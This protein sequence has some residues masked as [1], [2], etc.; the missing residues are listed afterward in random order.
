[1]AGPILASQVS[2]YGL[3]LFFFEARLVLNFGSVSASTPF[4]VSLSILALS[5]FPR[6]SPCRS[7]IA[8]G[9]FGVYTRSP[10]LPL[11]APEI[12]QMVLPVP[13]GVLA[14]LRSVGCIYILRH[15]SVSSNHLRPPF[16]YPDVVAIFSFIVVGS[17]P[18][19]GYSGWANVMSDMAHTYEYVAIDEI[20]RYMVAQD[21]HN[22]W[23]DASDRR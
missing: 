14:S 1:M 21:S 2:R 12:K 16:R 9:I 10:A 13:R 17:A 11:S 6:P 22:T 23:R 18:T 8:V 20:L 5:K 15:F 4:L 7:P 19:T 3:R